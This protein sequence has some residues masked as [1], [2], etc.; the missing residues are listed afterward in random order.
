MLLPQSSS[1]QQPG[2]VT[3]N[4]TLLRRIDQLEALIR[5]LQPQQRDNQH[6]TQ[7]EV[8]H[9]NDHRTPNN[10][11]RQ[12]PQQQPS[13]DSGP[14]M[15]ERSPTAVPPTVRSVPDQYSG[16]VEVGS[17]SHDSPMGQLRFEAFPLP[18]MLDM[19]P[20]PQHSWSSDPFLPVTQHRHHQQ[21]TS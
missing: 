11:D 5:L 4:D 15:S 20:L 10:Q 3:V 18:I 14:G 19:P 2:S 16:L 9:H 12:R 6:Q 17:P 13:P 21:S 1:Q 7:Q 8:G